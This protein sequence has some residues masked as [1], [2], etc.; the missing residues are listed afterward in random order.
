MT[1][2]VSHLVSRV[3]SFG[4]APTPVDGPSSAPLPAETWDDLLRE[5]TAER[6]TG[7]LHAAVVA[8][9]L[10]V[11]ADQAAA[12]AAAHAQARAQVLLLDA[13]LG[14]SLAALRTG[15]VPVLV[16]KG[17]AHAALLYDTPTLRSYGDLD[18]LVEPARL[19][20]AI[21]ALATVGYLPV[22][23]AGPA[24]YAPGCSY[25]QGLSLMGPRGV[26][27]DLHNRLTEPPF[28][29]RIDVED[30]FAGAQRL[31]IR[32][33]GVW[34]LS[35]EHRFLHCCLHA[36]LEGWPPRLVPLRDLAE[37]LRREAAMDWDGVEALIRRWSLR[38]VVS[39]SVRIM[40]SGLAV[41]VPDRLSW[42]SGYRPTLAERAALA[43]ARGRQD[44]PSM[45]VLGTMVALRGIRSRARFAHR[46]LKP[47]DAYLAGRYP[48]HRARW[49]ALATGGRSRSAGSLRTG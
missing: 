21:E 45:H 29:V 43:L 10:P 4:L 44:A 41:P 13:E 36:L 12:L 18:L 20:E 31:S 42:T 1:P 38:A 2:T 25:R 3:A 27:I 24:A 30:L 17:A 33:V 34:A 40:A 35:P 6:L 15:D 26:L 5:V 32:G 22:D 11:G 19:P 14:R 49:R 16:L 46:A 9:D 28:G 8:G 48:D 7:L 23:P 47:S 37:C 39:R